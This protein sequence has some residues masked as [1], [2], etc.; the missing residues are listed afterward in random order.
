MH[1]TDLFWPFLRQ[2]SALVILVWLTLYD[3]LWLGLWLRERYFVDPLGYYQVYEALPVAFMQISCIAVALA[4]IDLCP[5]VRD[6][7]KEE[8]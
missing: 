7:I 5:R 4:W 1:C 8:M 2:I 6:F 3:G